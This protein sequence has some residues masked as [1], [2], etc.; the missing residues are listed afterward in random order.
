[1][2]YKGHGT[3][4]DTKFEP[5]IKT[6]VN[7]A[8]VKNYGSSPRSYGWICPLCGRSVNPNYTNCN[9]G[10]NWTPTWRPNL[11]PWCYT[12]TKTDGSINF[13]SLQTF[14]GGSMEMK[15]VK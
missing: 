3:A 7:T 12:D 6:A 1:M 4:T 9:C 5:S 15:E 11:G 2:D 13:G 14:C 8:E 10:L